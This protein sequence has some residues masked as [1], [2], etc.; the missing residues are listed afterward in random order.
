MNDL[1]YLNYSKSLTLKNNLELGEKVIYSDKITKI[2]KNKV[3]QKRI[4]ILTNKNLYNIGSGFNIIKKIFNYQIKRKIK[5]SNIKAIIISKYSNNFILK[6]PKEY[7]YYL[8]YSLKEEFIQQILYYKTEDTK[9]LYVDNIDLFS[10]NNYYLKKENIY[11]SDNNKSDICNKELFNYITI[12]YNNK[13]QRKIEFKLFYSRKN[14]TIINEPFINFNIK[15]ILSSDNYINTIIIE[16]EGNHYFTKIIHNTIVDTS[17]IDSY[18]NFIDLHNYNN[19]IVPIEYVYYYN[20]NLFIIS[21]FNN[22]LNISLKLFYFK[23][24]SS[25]L[26]YFLISIIEYLD[27]INI[28]DNYK[29]ITQIKTNNILLDINGDIK[30]AKFYSNILLKNNY[31]HN[32]T[33]YVCPNHEIERSSNCIT[34]SVGLILFEIYFNHIPDKTVII[35]KLQSDISKKC[36]KIGDNSTEALRELFKKLLSNCQNRLN[37]NNLKINNFIE[38]ETKDSSFKENIK[39]DL[40]EYISKMTLIQLYF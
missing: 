1:D 9:I 39:K 23:E 6:I 22:T 12:K 11:W 32:N 7:D 38:I 35:S 27:S 14:N 37:L 34:W 20:N 28:N 36:F 4:F 13:L 31:K 8:S 21:K 33:I 5:L 15:K 26:K 40:V 18:I 30:I 17:S 16:F 3:K 19:Y 24:N 25:Y 29:F 10:L 2:N